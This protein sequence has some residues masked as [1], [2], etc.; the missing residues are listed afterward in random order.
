[1]LTVGNRSHTQKPP[2]GARIQYG[3]PLARGLVGCWLFNE[4]GGASLTNLVP[5]SPAGAITGATWRGGTPSGTA[6][7]FDGTDDWVNIPSNALIDNLS[8]L[9]VIFR[10]HYVTSRYFLDK[11]DGNVVNGDW[12][13]DVTGGN[14]RFRKELSTANMQ[15]QITAPA[16]STSFHFAV[17]WNGGFNPTTST[18]MYLNGI[19]QTKNNLITGSGSQANTNQALQIAKS[20]V[21]GT[22]LQGALEYLLIYNRVLDPVEVL[23]S[24]ASPFSFLIAQNPARRFLL[25]ADADAL[26]RFYYGSLLAADVRSELPGLG[27]LASDV[28]GQSL[29]RGL[30]SADVTV[31]EE[32]AGL[33]S[34]D[35]LHEIVSS[36][37]LS[38]DVTVS[39][40]G[41][42]LLSADV[43]GGDAA[44]LI[45]DLVNEDLR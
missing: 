10:G 30:L 37:S 17:T 16:A 42:G 45:V 36:G 2:V 43:E 20:K 23:W 34:A 21:D 25:T 29:A 9:T 3:H 1:M 35:V 28:F 31:P 27:L 4:A 7:S 11:S 6:L 8:L 38:A 5:A 26:T 12:M 24:Y 39:Q 22:F 40:E 15:A 32:G 41:A 44:P 13:I 14:I 33:L 18:R 19:E